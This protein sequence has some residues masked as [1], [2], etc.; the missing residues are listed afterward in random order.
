[1][2]Q[3]PSLQS[4]ESQSSTGSGGGSGENT[5]ANNTM[6]RGSLSSSGGPGTYCSQ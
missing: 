3:R 2:G 5:E 1:M 6:K 4:N